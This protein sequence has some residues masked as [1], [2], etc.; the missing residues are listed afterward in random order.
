M[1]EDCE[2][3]RVGDGRGGG[4]GSRGKLQEGPDA[5]WGGGCP[6]AG[7]SWTLQKAKDKNFGQWKEMSELKGITT[8]RPLTV[9]LCDVYL[10]PQKQKT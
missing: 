2:T 8:P 5:G 7:R 3:G 6:G 10:N 1:V 4:R 9:L